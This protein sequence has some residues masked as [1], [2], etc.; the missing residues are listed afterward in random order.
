MR[1]GVCKGVG[2][3]VCLQEDSDSENGGVYVSVDVCLGLRLGTV[4][5]VNYD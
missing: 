3:G 5:E 1:V 4:Y 2:V